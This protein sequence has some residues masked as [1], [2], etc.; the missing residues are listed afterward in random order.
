MNSPVPG[1]KSIALMRGLGAVRVRVRVRVKAR[2]RVRVRVAVAVTVRVRVRVRVRAEIDGVDARPGGGL[3]LGQYFHAL[4]A[5]LLVP[6]YEV[7]L[8]L[9]P[10]DLVRVRV[11]A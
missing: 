5:V 2:A 1:K 3:G 9:L 4:V 10:P 6:P 11:R 8:P 7:I